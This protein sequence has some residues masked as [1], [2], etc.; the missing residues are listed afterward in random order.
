[1]SNDPLAIGY[2]ILSLTVAGISGWI[3]YRNVEGRSKGVAVT[4]F[5]GWV[6]FAGMLGYTGILACKTPPGPVFVGVP[7][8]LIVFF[9]IVRNPNSAAF[10]ARVALPVLTG[11]QAYRVFVELGFHE[12][13]NRKMVPQLMTFRGLNFD[14]LIGVSA[15]VVALVAWKKPNL[16][17]LYRGWNIIGLLSVINAIMIGVLSFLGRTHGVPGGDVPNT[18]IGIFPFSF[19]P[20]L[21]APLAIVLH[22]LSLKALSVKEIQKQ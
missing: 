22:V 18:A 16:K 13:A 3:L 11:F 21:L 15:P 8:L 10:A 4:A 17:P 9:G 2:L 7:A 12:L 1:M 14:I 5:M 19:V 20:G 6:F